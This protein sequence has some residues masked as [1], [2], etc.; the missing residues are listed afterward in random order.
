MRNCMRHLLIFSPSL[1]SVAPLLVGIDNCT[2]ANFAER[3]CWF[4][5]FKH[6]QE[7]CD[8]HDSKGYCTSISVGLDSCG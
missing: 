7:H 4:K 6:V 5:Q 8:L 3:F 1:S 2:V